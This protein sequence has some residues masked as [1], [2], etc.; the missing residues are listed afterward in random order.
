MKKIITTFSSIAFITLFILLVS[1]DNSQTVNY[2]IYK[3]SG[4]PTDKESS[5]MWSNTGSPG[6]GGATCAACHSGG[7]TAE[8]SWISTTIPGTGYV[9]GQTYTITLTIAGGSP[10]TGKGF[11]I[12]CE[13]TSSVSVGTLTV[14]DAINTF[15][16]QDHVSHTSAGKTLSSWSM[17]WTAPVAGTGTATFY[18]AFVKNGYAGGVAT[19]SASFNEDT[20]VGISN[21]A[22]EVDFNLFPNP[23][24]EVLNIE[25]SS[26]SKN[27]I[28]INIHSV[29]G[30]NIY[31][32]DVN[33]NNNTV[34]KSLNLTNLN[35]D[36]GVYFVTFSYDNKSV[37]KKI[38]VK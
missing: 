19:A 29:L 8:N 21:F 6:D 38:M 18:A 27:K 33:V 37:T 30:Q 26:I 17:D 3:G 2:D 15:F 13:N 4:H 22:N 25:L 28:T 7:V 34:N 11:S 5:G 1:F 31:T 24:S 32:E 35:L 12:V 9:P 20:S 36:S 16:D 14:T 23:V 10:T